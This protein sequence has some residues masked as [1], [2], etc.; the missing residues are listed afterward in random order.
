ME[1]IMLIDANSLLYR[2]FFALPP[3]ENTTGQPTRAVY[4]F[5]NM[6]MKLLEDYPVDYAVAAFD[7]PGPTKRSQEYKEYKANRPP[8]P[9][10]LRS[11]MQIARDVLAALGIPCVDLQ[12]YEADDLVGTAARRANEDG[13]FSWIVSG[14]KDIL[15][16]VGTKPM[17]SSP[18]G[19]L[20]RPR[21]TT[22][23]LCKSGTRSARLKS[24][25][26]RA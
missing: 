25:T 6:L 14:D 12:G 18:N 2:A 10:E 7:L 24:W 17:S 23:R 13:C 8:T 22:P 15:Q 26:S 9:F 21:S 5:I 16:L 1:K 20:P 19:E 11:Q 3:L 4:G